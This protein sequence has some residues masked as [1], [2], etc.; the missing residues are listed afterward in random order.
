MP[1]APSAQWSAGAPVNGWAGGPS[2]FGGNTEPAPEAKADAACALASFRLAP[3]V[4]VPVAC[5]GACADAALL[6]A[7]LMAEHPAAARQTAA[8]ATTVAAHRERRPGPRPSP[9]SNMSSN[10][11]H[12]HI[13]QESLS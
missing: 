1:A 7:D 4:S 8:S 13:V 12:G 6:T 11:Q 3:V 2:G 5:C 9:R 10:Q